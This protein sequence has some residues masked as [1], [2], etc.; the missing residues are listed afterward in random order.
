MADA[1]LAE[2]DVRAALARIAAQ[3]RELAGDAE[4]VYST[5]TCGEG[6]GAL[7][8]AGLQDWLWHKLATKYLTDETGYMARLAEAA[9]LLFDE[10]GLARYATICRSDTTARV[11]DAYGSSTAEGLRALKAAV[12]ASGIEPPDIDGFSWGEVSGLEEAGARSAVEAALEQAIA[13]GVL[14]VGGRGWRQAQQS[15]TAATLDGLHPTQPAQSWRTALV[16]ERVGAWTA[17]RRSDE[18]SRLRRR[19][20]NR[21]LH[22][23]AA[24][25]D[26]D[27]H[28]APLLWLLDNFG[29]EQALTQ[30]GYVNTGFLRRVHA[31]GP[32][33]NRLAPSAP[34]RSEIDDV[35]LHRLRGLLEGMG[36]LRKRRNVLR[37]TRHGA[38]LV[39]DPAG[40][41]AGFVG[42]MG[43]DPWKRFVVETTGTVLLDAGDDGVEA[44][45]LLGG[46]A[47]IAAE[48]G[49]RTGSTAP[50]GA[51]VSWAFSGTRATL[52]LFGMLNETG[53]WRHR[54]F[55][56]T[57]TGEATM[58]ARLHTIAAG[59]QTHPAALS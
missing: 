18:L 24:P 10:L 22:P 17:A 2:T 15:I 12:A 37:R 39:G 9:A 40:L 49:W 46:V 14:V 13:T 21:L 11:H 28:L 26:L 25:A 52:G 45:A 27:E 51:D 58:L 1:E 34:P 32:W 56:L 42:A 33:S 5:L 7:S 8:Q 44:A 19:L 16:T 59:P 23:T 3:D 57:P 36:A 30:A 47:A 43:A 35:T 54:R 50:S 29:D 4:H 41:W 38:A 55:G 53:D 20:A 48:M 31:E 6:P